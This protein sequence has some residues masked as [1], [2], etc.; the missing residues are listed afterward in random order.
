MSVILAARGSTKA[1][2][3]MH[4]LTAGLMILAAIALIETAP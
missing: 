1:A 4:G 2:L 3:G